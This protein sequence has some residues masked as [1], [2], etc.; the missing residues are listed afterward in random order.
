MLQSAIQ[1]A[2]TRKGVSVIGLPG[3]LAKASAVAVDSSIE[4]SC[5]TGVC[6]RKKIWLN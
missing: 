4:L 6:R 2:V 5:P 3:D 1:T